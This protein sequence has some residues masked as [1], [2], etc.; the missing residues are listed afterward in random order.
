MKD[1]NTIQS[2]N[3]ASEMDFSI[4][5]VLEDLLLKEKCSMTELARRI[6]IRHYQMSLY[7]NGRL[8][9]LETAIKIA[10]YMKCSLDYLFSF[11]NEYKE[12]DAPLVL[13][14]YGFYDKYKKLLEENNISHFALS[15]KIDIC[16]T[17]LSAWKNHQMPDTTAILEIASYFGVSIDYLVCKQKA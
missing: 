8:P 17:R 13:D 6:G 3:G 12:T 2:K 1:T 14:V 5:E 11:A 9:K 15:K 16:E 7:L 10:N 4:V